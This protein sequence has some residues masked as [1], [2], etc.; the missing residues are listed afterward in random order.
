MDLASISDI[1]CTHTLEAIFVQNYLLSVTCIASMHALPTL[2]KILFII[3][4]CLVL[5][6]CHSQVSTYDCVS[7]IVLASAFMVAVQHQ[8]LQVHSSMSA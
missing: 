6:S 8:K 4:G 5:V 3:V 7:S 1:M 2:T